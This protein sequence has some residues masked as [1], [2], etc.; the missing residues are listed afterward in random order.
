MILLQ[1]NSGAVLRFHLPVRGDTLN[2]IVDR[3]HPFLHA[4]SLGESHTLLYPVPGE[5]RIFPEDDRTCAPKM[6]A[7]LADEFSGR[8][9]NLQQA[10]Y[11]TT[12]DIGLEWP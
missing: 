12:S 10:R 2:A 11:R 8:Y 5:S 3:P 7:F 6:C 9:H 4:V 1:K